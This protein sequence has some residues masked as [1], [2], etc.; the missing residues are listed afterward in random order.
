MAL[1]F[2]CLCFSSDPDSKTYLEKYPPFS[3]YHH[4]LEVTARNKATP[5]LALQPIQSELHLL[6]S[7]SPS[8]ISTSS[9][10]SEMTDQTID[11]LAT[12]EQDSQSISSSDGSPEQLRSH[13]AKGS[14]KDV[15]ATDEL[16]DVNE[17][18]GELVNDV[19]EDE[20]TI[21]NS[22]LI[23]SSNLKLSPN[24][25]H[26]KTSGLQASFAKS[27]FTENENEPNVSYSSY[28]GLYDRPQDCPSRPS[29]SYSNDSN[30]TNVEQNVDEWKRDGN[31]DERDQWP[32]M[33]FQNPYSVKNEFSLDTHPCANAAYESQMKPENYANNIGYPAQNMMYDS[34]NMS[35]Y[36]QEMQFSSGFRR[37]IPSCPR[38]HFHGYAM[39]QP[40]VDTNI[41]TGRQMQ[42]GFQYPAMQHTLVP[43][44][45]AYKSCHP[46]VIPPQFGLL[47]QTYNYG[48]NNLH[49]L[50]HPARA[51]YSPYLR[52]YQ[53]FS[54]NMTLFQQNMPTKFDKDVPTLT[55]KD[56][57]GKKK[58][59]VDNSA[60][61][62]MIN[63]HAT[64]A[65]NQ[66]PM[67]P[68]H[69]EEFKEEPTGQDRKSEPDQEVSS[70]TMSHNAAKD[71]AD[72]STEKKPVLKKANETYRVSIIKAILSSSA[73]RL[74]LSEIY[75]KI[76]EMQ[77]IYRD[78]ALAWKNAVRHNLSKSAC[79][80]KVG[81]TDVGRGFYWAIHPSCVEPFRRGDFDHRQ[82]AK[83]IKN[84]D[85]ENGTS[86][87][88]RS[89]VRPAMRP[90]MPAVYQPMT[91]VPVGN[92]SYNNPALQI[93]YVPQYYP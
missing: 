41:T 18:D 4:Q 10:K 14:D 19:S 27:E 49:Q 21:S 78:S 86:M 59:V 61:K 89:T 74:S 28:D 47:N 55:L 44:P 91:S 84:A 5:M 46:P 26:S 52:P 92:M 58:Q 57:S 8:C 25:P 23:P 73:G 40:M 54:P 2:Y 3:Y 1:Y 42:G 32:S 88:T 11:K 81:R 63:T 56:L 62:L 80:I 90:T 83:R 76:L 43:R 15:D 7:K 85:R 35:N 38:P 36:G 79:F 64:L 17:N 34:S 71:T 33:V 77:P 65:V 12:G 45:P 66:T 69:F 93:P 6:K 87:P 22:E 48:N 16:S 30:H 37:P 24:A 39:H 68:L 60:P 29:S 75:E 70:S 50:N 20:E 13:N 82:A 31:A 9:D 53:P 51:R 72:N 67:V